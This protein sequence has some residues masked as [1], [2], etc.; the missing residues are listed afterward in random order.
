M[1]TLPRRLRCSGPDA[2]DA[3]KCQGLPARAA[4]ILNL[5][6]QADY[7]APSPTAGDL[8]AGMAQ[9]LSA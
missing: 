2:V 4:Q 5:V 3:S 9:A 8:A 7:P 1:R 6:E